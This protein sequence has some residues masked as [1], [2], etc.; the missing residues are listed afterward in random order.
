MEQKNDLSPAALFRRTFAGETALHDEIA[1]ACVR[2]LKNGSLALFGDSEENALLPLDSRTMAAVEKLEAMHPLLAAFVREGRETAARVNAAPMRLG[3]YFCE[4]DGQDGWQANWIGSALGIYS[5]LFVELDFIFLSP[6]TE[7][8][9]ALGSYCNHGCG[10]SGADS[11]FFVEHGWVD[12]SALARLS[13]NDAQKQAK[14]TFA[15]RRPF[16]C[17]Y[18]GHKYV[19][20]G[21]MGRKC[22]NC[23][24]VLP[25]S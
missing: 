3:Y 12:I 9:A 1:E 24:K 11:A 15:S 10:A 4:L 23:K 14:R 7:Y 21:L 22:P 17:P 2:G 18:C 16:P 25:K 5:D 13:A 20:S 19:K 6:T 8:S